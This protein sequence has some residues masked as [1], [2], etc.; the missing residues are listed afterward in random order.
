MRSYL[1]HALYSLPVLFS[2]TAGENIRIHTTLSGYLS[3]FD[4]KHGVTSGGQPFQAVTLAEVT[5]FSNLILSMREQ[6][7]L[8]HFSKS[9]TIL[10]CRLLGV[11]IE[12]FDDYITRH[13]IEFIKGL[14]A[15]SFFHHE[16]VELISSFI[17][18]YETVMKWT[19]ERGWHLKDS[20]P[21]SLECANYH[22]FLA[23]QPQKK[24]DVAD[25]AE[26][27]KKLKWPGHDALA[28]IYMQS[29]YSD[30]KHD[31][32]LTNHRF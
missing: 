20:T 26:I 27:A 25:I 14:K 21:F 12:N 23:L 3:E 9:P 16:N 17:S 2:S 30:L 24:A 22:I 1:N 29:F 5:A 11:I 32:A 28:E 4:S 19:Q 7:L 8:V 13:P 10:L 31:T 15:L 6:Q 18:H